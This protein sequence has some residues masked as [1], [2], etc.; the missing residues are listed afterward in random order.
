MEKQHQKSKHKGYVEPAIIFFVHCVVAVIVVVLAWT[1][2]K[3][4]W[5][6]LRFCALFLWSKV[7]RSKSQKQTTPAPA[8]G[9]GLPT[10]ECFKHSPNL[11]RAKEIKF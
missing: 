4:V 8:L 11:A 10:P 5:P 9:N 7:K 2:T 3:I 6:V 1:L